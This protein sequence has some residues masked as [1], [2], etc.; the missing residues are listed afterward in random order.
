[1]DATTPPPDGDQNRGPAFLISSWI[2]VGIVIVIMILR[3]YG[4]SRLGQVGVDDWVMLLTAALLIAFVSV[5]SVVALN[6]GFRHVYYLKSNMDLVFYVTK[7]NWISQ[8]PIIIAL[9]TSKISV[10]FLI[11]RVMGHSKWRKR[12]LYFTMVTCFIGNALSAIFTFAQCNPPKALWSTIQGKCWDPATQ[13]DYAIAS[14]CYNG[15]LD[16][17]YALLPASVFWNL[18]LSTRKKIGLVLLLGG[19]IFAGVAS[20]IKSSKLPGLSGRSDFTWNSYEPIVCV[21]VFLLIVCG[22][23]PALKPIYDQIFGKPKGSSSPYNSF[24]RRG[25]RIQSS[26]DDQSL[27]L[28][29]ISAPG[30]TTTTVVNSR[31][32]SD[33]CFNSR[34]NKDVPPLPNDIN[35]KKTFEV[36]VTGSRLPSHSDQDVVSGHE[37]V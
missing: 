12:F 15:V 35:I 8:P 26:T 32:K 10:G 36:S 2:E 24:S 30:K 27:T 34:S 11:L 4:R 6:G 37:V 18:Q 31:P 1:M 29:R 19:G 5:A 22:S 16:V 21:E 3:F 20:F 28:K 7:F 14:S 9:A 25:Y 33:A 23:I 17:A 13:S